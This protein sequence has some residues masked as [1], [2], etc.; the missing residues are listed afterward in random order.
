MNDKTQIDKTLLDRLVIIDIEGYN[1]K[2]KFEIAKKY[3]IPKAI[4]NIGLAK[5]SVIFN[6][7]AIEHLIQ[8]SGDENELSGVRQLKYLIEN[9]LMKIN[10]LRTT[11]IKN[12]TNKYKIDLSFS[13]KDFKLPITIT[14]HIINELN[15]KKEKMDDI[16]FLNMYM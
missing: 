5:K 6:D 16:S 3:L 14:S 1:R 10:L 2:E 11:T 8:I 4:E 9:I 15:I 12:N 7:E 13:I